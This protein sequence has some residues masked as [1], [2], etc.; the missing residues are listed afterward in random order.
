MWLIGGIVLGASGL[1]GG[2]VYA[3]VKSSQA[4]NTGWDLVGDI[5]LGVLIGG[6]VG[7]AAGA[8]LGA[9]ISIDW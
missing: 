9:G 7:F 6:V 2:G 5:A 3:G 4:G 1:I 8:L